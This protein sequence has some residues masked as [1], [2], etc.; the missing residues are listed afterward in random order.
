M[1]IL[2]ITTCPVFLIRYRLSGTPC[3][4]MRDNDLK[5]SESISNFLIWKRCEL[6]QRSW[7]KVKKLQ[8]I[9]VCPR[10]SPL[11][12]HLKCPLFIYHSKSLWSRRVVNGISSTRTKRTLSLCYRIGSH[13]YRQGSEWTTV[14]NLAFYFFWRERKSFMT[15]TDFIFKQHNCFKLGANNYFKSN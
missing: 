4:A 10:L 11:N 1:L 3:P 12:G 13:R 5:V 7:F 15:G 8:K 2:L 6:V 9:A 14:G